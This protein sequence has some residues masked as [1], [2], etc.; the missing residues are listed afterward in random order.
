MRKTVLI[1]CLGAVLCS[2]TAAA[3]TMIPFQSGKAWGYKDAQGKVI[4]EARYADASQAVDGFGLVSLYDGSG[5][6]W[7]VVSSDG[8]EV[9]PV[10]YD[11]V[12]M[13]NDGMVAV[14]TGPVDAES[15]YMAGGQWKFISLADLSESAGSY[16]LVG[17]YVDGLAWVNSKPTSMKRQMRVMPILDKKGKPTG[18]ENIIFGVS[19]SFMLED[20][21]VPD[22]SG[23]VVL[24]DAEW[25]LI[26]RNGT[27]VTDAASP[28]QAV[29]MFENGLAWVK[30][31]GL[32][33][34]I[35]TSGEEVI[36]VKYV[37]VQDAPG[38]HPAALLLNPETGAVRWV[39]N[40]AGQIA[41][42]NETGEVVIDFIDSDGRVSV[43]DTVD[44]NMWDY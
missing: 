1:S 24:E 38:S 15:L 28:Y 7:G 40:E 20:M 37:T 8:R 23:N 33:G 25:V 29:G 22:D 27:A 14:Y 18:E 31:G 39:M 30:R 2:A 44:E 9:L 26:D 5:Y 12:D 43:F 13:C 11:Y 16:N 42:L 34:F 41:W 35:N 17:P 19:A 6:K 3:Q 4:V 36:P 10:E 21:I 32:F